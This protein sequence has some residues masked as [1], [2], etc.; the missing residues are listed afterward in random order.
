MLLH[1]KSFFYE[2]GSWRPI[3]NGLATHFLSATCRQITPVIID[4]CQK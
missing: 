1:D 2:V 3:S 4:N